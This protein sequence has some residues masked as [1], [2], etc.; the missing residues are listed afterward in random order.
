MSAPG[1]SW[2]AASLPDTQLRVLRAGDRDYAVSIG[3]PKGPP[4][5][6]GFPVLYVLDGDAGF[7]TVLETQ[8][9]L[10]RRPDATGV[11]PAIVVGIGHGGGDLYDPALRQRDYLPQAGAP[12][13]LDFI[14]TVLKPL[15]A[16]EFPVDPGRQALLGHSLAGYFTLWVLVRHTRAFTDYVA[17]SPSL[18][19][20]DTLVEAAAAV[21]GPVSRVAIAAGEWEEALPPWQRRHPEAEAVAARRAERRMVG[22]ARQFAARLA[23]RL[24]QDKVA[25]TLFAEEDHA[26]V[27]AIAMSRALRLVL[28]P[29]PE[30]SA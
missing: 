8:R 3:L 27:F 4:P 2:P 18:W 23:G 30:G 7:A 26:S 20:D 9:R 14:A 28:A 21:A 24:G 5:A 19:Q 12:A 29:Q 16:S 22:N 1:G 25:F 13:F 17:I 10:S 15:L 11:G 6:A